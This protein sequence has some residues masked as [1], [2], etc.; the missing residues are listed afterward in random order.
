MSNLAQTPADVSQRFSLRLRKDGLLPRILLAISLS[1]V[2]AAVLIL[3]A[4]K[5]PLDAF[6][7]MLAGAFGSPHQI[8]VAL[9]RTSPYLF[10]GAGLAL[11]FRAGVINMGSDGQ[12][13]MG[14]IGATATILTWPGTPGAVAAIAALI[15]AALAGAL[16]AGL[17][18]AIHLSRR[19]HEVLAT[20]LLNFVALLLVQFLLSSALGQPGA[21]FLQSPLMPRS[22]WLPRIP[23]FDFH[24]GIILAIIVAA[25][26]S[27]LLWKTSFGFGVRVA[28]RSR[29][30]AAYAGFSIA[31][32]TWQLM[33]GAGAMAGLG[34][35][36]EILGL[37][38]R[39]IE[40]FSNGFGFKAVTVALLGALEP[41]LT[42]PAALFIGFLETGA[43]AMQRQ[44]GVPSSLVTVIEAATILFILAATVRRT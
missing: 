32:I 1:L 26:V 23:A 28:G 13:A 42:I 37:Q 24:I 29:P 41:A 10:A 5:N 12:I 34:G 36:V 8:G 6:A 30:A 33:L 43:L 3:L 4:Q 20:L 40:G 21:G 17:A 18:T 25:F 35:G 22:V 11:C 16:W 27:F 38:H 14:G 7:A 44:I 15:A 9:N 39:L 19:V 2:V 31:A